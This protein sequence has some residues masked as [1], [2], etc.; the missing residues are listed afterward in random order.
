MSSLQKLMTDLS[1]IL[2][3]TNQQYNSSESA[4]LGAIDVY[5][6]EAIYQLRQP[7]IGKIS[8]LLGQSTPNT[9]YHIKKLINLGLIDKRIDP[10]DHRVTHLATTEKYT[11]S[12]NNNQEFWEN[13]QRRLED[14][15][16]PRDFAIFKRVLGQAVELV[17]EDL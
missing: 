1:Q 10:A 12:L 15:I 6:L 14:E 5:Y 7:T 16:E 8:R 2:Q 11:S 9:N 3:L 17:H 13:L 4:K